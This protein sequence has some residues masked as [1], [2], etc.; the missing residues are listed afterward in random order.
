MQAG[1]PSARGTVAAPASCQLPP[2]HVGSRGECRARWLWLWLL[3]IWGLGSVRRFTRVPHMR[4]VPQPC[5]RTSLAAP[6]AL[7]QQLRWRAACAGNVGEPLAAAAARPSVGWRRRL[8]P[9]LALASGAGGAS[10]GAQSSKGVAA[11]RLLGFRALDLSDAQ[12]EIGIVEEASRRCRRHAPCSLLVPAP[13]LPYPS[14]A[15]PPTH[16]SCWHPPAGAGHGGG[17]PGAGAAAGA[18]PCRREGAEERAS[19]G[20]PDPLCAPDRAQ[21][22][23]GSRW[24]GSPMPGG[25]AQAQAGAARAVQGEAVSPRCHPPTCPCLPRRRRGVRPAARGTAGAGQAAEPAGNPGVSRAAGSR[26]PALRLRLW[27][28]PPD[29]PGCRALARLPALPAHVACRAC[30]PA[31]PPACRRDLE[32]F[33]QPAP[34]SVLQRMGLRTMPTSAQLEA[35]GRRDLVAAVR[36]AG[37]FLE[38]AQVGGPACLPA[39]LA[40]CRVLP[41]LLRSVVLCPA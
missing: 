20:A 8:G 3:F 4:I 21:R 2:A 34:L 36:A 28:R 39:C 13:T 1:R 30:L 40:R 41:L 16:P 15:H 29:P 38:V 27:P 23:P 24:E 32:P 19:G 26:C 10:T 18:A 37:G 6:H 17:G 9:P 22:G 11:K 5:P 25:T 31:C 7:L 14:P 12:A 35:A 33:T